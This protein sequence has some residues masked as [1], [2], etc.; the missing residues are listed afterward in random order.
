VSLTSKR[1][2]STGIGHS[3]SMQCQFFFTCREP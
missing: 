3:M 1:G 2:M